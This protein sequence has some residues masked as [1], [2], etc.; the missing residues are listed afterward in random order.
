[1]GRL[2]KYLLMGVT[3]VTHK[4]IMVA[5]NAIHFKRISGIKPEDRTISE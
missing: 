3:S 1:M 4:L 2:P 5:N